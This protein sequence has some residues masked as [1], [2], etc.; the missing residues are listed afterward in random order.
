MTAADETIARIRRDLDRL[1]KS[2]RLRKAVVTSVDPLRVMIADSGVE[3]ESVP[4]LAGANLSASEIV[5][6]LEAEGR[7]LILGTYSATAQGG[8]FGQ[9]EFYGHS[10]YDTGTSKQS[11]GIAPR[12]AAMLGAEPV[13]RGLPGAR[14]SA[15]DQGAHTGDLYYGDGGW[16]TVYRYANPGAHAA[17]YEPARDAAVLLYGVNDFYLG[18]ADAAWL[19][20]TYA[21]EAVISRLR[22]AAVFEDTDSSVTYPVGS[23]STVAGA[24]EPARAQS[25]TGVHRTTSSNGKV[26]IAVPADFPGGTIA[27]GFLCDN[28]GKGAKW[29][30]AVDGGASVSLD[31]RAMNGNGYWGVR[32][33]RL[34][35]LEDGAHTITATVNTLST[36]GY[37]DCWWIEA[38]VPPAVIVAGITYTTGQAD[39]DVDAANARLLAVTDAFADPAVWYVGLSGTIGDADLSD[40]LHVNDAGAAKIAAVMT[41]A[42]LSQKRSTDAH[43]RG[44][45]GGTFLNRFPASDD[46]NTIE[47]GRPTHPALV[48]RDGVHPAEVDLLR[49]EAHDGTL[50][51]GIDGA[52]ALMATGAIAMR[53]GANSVVLG[54]LFGKSIVL[55]D[56]TDTIYLESTGNLRTASHFTADG[57]LIGGGAVMADTAAGYVTLGELFGKQVVIFS[58]DSDG[59]VDTIYQNA[60]DDLRTAATFTSKIPAN[61]TPAAFAHPILGGASGAA[62]FAKLCEYL[63]VDVLFP[64]TATGVQYWVG[65]TQ[66]GNVR[67]ALYTNDGQTRLANRTSNSAQPATGTLH[68]VAFDS[69]YAFAT[70]GR[71]YIALIFDNQT[72]TQIVG[73]GWLPMTATV[74][75][76]FATPATVTTSTAV[77]SAT[78]IGAS[79]Y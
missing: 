72:A 7:A 5:A 63:A 16:A 42:L 36:Y 37:F 35:G 40:G 47:A 8:G 18:T 28:S 71:Y 67:S 45:A 24:T 43:A 74:E 64:C 75:G 65:T 48:L 22:A 26:Q 56:G 46:V 25:G 52:G 6:V 44:A 21:L 15:S 70:P 53:A 68:K 61:V 73:N 20:A 38:E 17:P 3:L 51:A 31:A 54:T 32:V 19:P 49:V 34:T 33:L 9:V 77:P 2:A 66:A 13:L 59:A 12:V 11:R 60:K 27:L 76:S 78:A 4:A 30:V 50:V 57:G 10:L 23:W 62:T 79:L 14:L 58:T 39:A 55:F 29:D 1:G 41:S 69:T